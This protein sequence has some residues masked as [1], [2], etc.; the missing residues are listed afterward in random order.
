MT[1]CAVATRQNAMMIQVRAG[2]QLNLGEESAVFL[3]LPD[4]RTISNSFNEVKQ[5][6]SIRPKSVGILHP[7]WPL[8][9][10]RFWPLG[11]ILLDDQAIIYST[12]HHY[13]E[14]QDCFDCCEVWILRFLNNSRLWLSSYVWD[15]WPIDLICC[16]ECHLHYQV[17][18]LTQIHI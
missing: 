7:L 8:K 4:F 2:Q 16:P 17:C 15:S 10:R 12:P 1:Q 6:P 13:D 9:V 11:G 14:N 18:L 5:S 3:W